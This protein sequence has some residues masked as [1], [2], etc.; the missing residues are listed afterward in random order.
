MPALY[1]H[2]GVEKQNQ[3]L[4][5]IMYPTCEKGLTRKHVLSYQNLIPQW[6]LVNQI[7]T[8]IS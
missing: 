2:Q 3:L 4:T 8:L 7:V 5:H 1:K 6:F